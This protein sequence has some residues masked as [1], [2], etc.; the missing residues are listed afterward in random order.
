MN[1]E[2]NQYM[3]HNFQNRGNPKWL[4]KNRGRDLFK[5]FSWK[6]KKLSSQMTD[7]ENPFL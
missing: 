7:N 3:L 6:I 5:L 2:V 1:L 4:P